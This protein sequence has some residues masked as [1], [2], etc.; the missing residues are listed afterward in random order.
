MRPEVL[1]K[2]SEFSAED[3]REWIV[4]AIRRQPV[5]PPLFLARDEDVQHGIQDAYASL[6]SDK[7]RDALRSGLTQA[8][9]STPVLPH[10]EQTRIQFA[11]L[12]RIAAILKPPD[13]RNFLRGLL[14]TE[15]F[16]GVEAAG[17]DLHC[18]LVGV[19]AKYGIDS[20]F[21]RDLHAAIPRIGGWQYP[22]AC[23][24]SVALGSADGEEACR[25]LDYLVPALADGAIA[26]KLEDAMEV[27]MRMH[28]LESISRW[29]QTHENST[30]REHPRQLAL[31]EARLNQLLAK[32]RTRDLLHALAL[33]KV[34][35]QKYGPEAM[36]EFVTGHR[37]E[38]DACVET[39]GKLH[40]L[41]LNWKLNDP[42]SLVLFERQYRPDAP[43]TLSLNG[44][45]IPLDLEVHEQEYWIFNEA[46]RYTEMTPATLTLM[47]QN[48][49]M[50]YIV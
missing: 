17:A 11:Y 12:F 27:C 15:V 16:S 3:W 8:L 38:R 33:P 4:G 48:Y 40:E 5:S 26:A 23:F 34:L 6:P 21:I 37:R 29:Y 25:F 50:T 7:M 39:L 28:G 1:K 30:I 22:L 36:N 32:A 44:H 41:G 19:C 42:H 20:Q 2:Y 35:F 13:A 49:G 18:L 10:D 45:D 46:M 47:R 31:L 43:I 14:K 9:T 24:R